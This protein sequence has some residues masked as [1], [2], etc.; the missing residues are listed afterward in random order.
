MLISWGSRVDLGEGQKMGPPLSLV[1]SPDWEVLQPT[2]EA[3]SGTSSDRAED[4][5]SFEEME[6]ECAASEHSSCDDRSY[7]ELFEVVT[8]TVDS[9]QLDWPQEKE[10]TR[11]SKL[12]DRFLSGGQGEAPERQIYK[13]SWSKPYSSC[14]FVP[15]T[16]IY[17]TIIGAKAQ[18]YTMMPQVEE[19]LWSC[20]RSVFLLDAPMLP[21]SLCGDSV[22]FV[23]NRFREAKRH[24][25]I[26]HDIW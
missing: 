1:F 18:G 10:T 9:L 3:H 16:L 22:N 13:K 20:R 6:F 24:K 7:D 19:I 5:S 17:S 23:V 2:S 8:R 4:V 11:R 25:E 26:Q 15:A 14:V 21:S 12:H